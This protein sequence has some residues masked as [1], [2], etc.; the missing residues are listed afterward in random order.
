MRHLSKRWIRDAIAL[1]PDAN[2]PSPSS[3]SGVVGDGP[4]AVPRDPEDFAFVFAFKLS[5]RGL[6]TRDP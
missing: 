4:C 5:S 1:K 6:F 3:Q 2:N